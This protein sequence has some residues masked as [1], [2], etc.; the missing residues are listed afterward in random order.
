M[1]GSG[2][3]EEGSEARPAEVGVYF[4]S[5]HGFQS[6]RRFAVPLRQLVSVACGCLQLEETRQ[7]FLPRGDK[8]GSDDEA[9]IRL[10][11]LLLLNGRLSIRPIPSI[12]F[13]V[14]AGVPMVIPEGFEILI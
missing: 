14:F 4:R 6:A 5:S 10:N 13:G 7:G 8:D 2:G 9:V 3:G 1:C 11:Y 12:Y